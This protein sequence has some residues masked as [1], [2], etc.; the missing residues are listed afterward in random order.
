MNTHPDE[1]LS[2][3]ATNQMLS[4]IELQRLDIETLVAR[5]DVQAITV[6]QI[7]RMQGVLARSIENLEIH[8]VQ[9]QNNRGEDMRRLWELERPGRIRRTMQR[10][11]WPRF[12]W[13][14]RIERWS[15]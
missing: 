9:L 4:N 14:L 12:P 1:E 13:R 7:E 5:V 3:Y 11:R 15:L 2:Q 8:I 10:I 6:E